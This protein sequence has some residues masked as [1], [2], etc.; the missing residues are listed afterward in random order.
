MGDVFM[1]M[2]IVVMVTKALLLLLNHLYRRQNHMKL[3]TISKVKVIHPNDAQHDYT[4][5]RNLDSY[6]SKN[7]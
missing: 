3:L 5:S 2:D 4:M 7:I 1:L 6:L